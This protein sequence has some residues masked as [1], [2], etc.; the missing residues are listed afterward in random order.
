MGIVSII[1]NI[2]IFSIKILLNIIVLIILGIQK[3]YI[4]S[5]DLI[6]I[7]KEKIS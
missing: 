4:I 7:I 5:N 3:S 1:D 2:K 6:E